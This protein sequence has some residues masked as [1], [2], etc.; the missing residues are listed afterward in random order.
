MEDRTVMPRKRAMTIIDSDEDDEEGDLLSDL[1]HPVL[2]KTRWDV[3]DIAYGPEDLIKAL[4]KAGFHPR[5]GNLPNI[6]CNNF[7]L[8]CFPP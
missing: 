1:S 6:L 4:T 2:K 8:I 3:E 5:S 7:Y